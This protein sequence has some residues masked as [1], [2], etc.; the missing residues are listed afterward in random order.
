[1][2]NGGGKIHLFLTS[3]LDRMSGQLCA[4][5]LY[6]WA[7]H[8][9]TP[10]PPQKGVE[11]VEIIKQNKSDKRIDTARSTRWYN[12]QIIVLQILKC[13]CAWDNSLRGPW[14]IATSVCRTEGQQVKQ[15]PCSPQNSEV[16]RKEAISGCNKPAM[17]L[18]ILHCSE[19]WDAD[20]R[21]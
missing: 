15:S 21:H 17:G 6:P 5:P 14:D 10:P 11:I 7:L 16:G 8:V 2:W 19:N 20:Q 9:V 13:V 1:M 18:Q 4:Q 12:W 3:A